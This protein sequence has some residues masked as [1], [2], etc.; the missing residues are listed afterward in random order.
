M[1]EDKAWILL[2]KTNTKNFWFDD[3]KKI[4]EHY[5]TLSRIRGSHHIYKTG[6]KI[7]GFSTVNIQPDKRD[8]SKAKSVQVENVRTA[9]ELLTGI[10]ED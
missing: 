1:R 8:S 7:Q 10:K 5:F 6:L 3:L 2:F 9:V 4:C